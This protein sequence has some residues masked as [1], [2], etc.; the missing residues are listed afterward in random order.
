MPSS[1]FQFRALAQLLRLPNLFTAAA[2]PL[3]G[4]L[5]VGG[6]WTTELVPLLGASVCLYAS[7]VVFNDSFDF[8]TDSRERPERP[9]P[10]GAFTRAFAWTLAGALMLAG[11]ALAWLNGTA[12]LHKALIIAALVLVYNAARKMPGVMGACR[13]F[14]LMLGMTGNAAL[15]PPIVLG[16]YVT[17]VTV[18]ARRETE[19]AAV[20]RWVKRL[21]LGII[22][23]DAALVVIATGDWLGALGVLALLAPAIFLARSLEM[24]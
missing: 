20:R 11:V 23:L 18:V 5:I 13:A 21:L 19:N 7:G 10:S 12:A 16:A 17:A 3:A 22:A 8:K 2:D 14:N 6:V 24:T 4:W 1:R 15:W 9:L